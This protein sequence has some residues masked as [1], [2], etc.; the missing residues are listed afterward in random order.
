MLIPIAGI[1][2]A[3]GAAVALIV[4]EVNR[5]RAERREMAEFAESIKRLPIDRQA[6]LWLAYLRD[7][8]RRDLF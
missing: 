7:E 3:A 8:A 5:G 1:I 2:L 4:A 6:E